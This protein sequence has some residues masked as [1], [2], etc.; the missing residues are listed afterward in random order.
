M[1]TFAL[2]NTCNTLLTALKTAS[3]NKNIIKLSVDI[4]LPDLLKGNATILTNTVKA[5]ALYLSDVLIN[6]VIHIE[7][8]SRGTHGNITT[9][10]VS[11]TGLGNSRS[12][13][14]NTEQEF[15][16]I[17]NNSDFK[18]QFK[19]SED[20]LIFEFAYTL[21][22][23]ESNGVTAAL[24]FERRKILVVEDNEINAMVFSS[25]LEDWGALPA[26]AVNGEEAV[27][28]AHD[29]KYDAILMDIHMP[30]LNGNQATKKIRDFNHDIPIIALTASSNEE[31]FRDAM[32]CGANEYLQKPVSSTNLFQVLSK[33]L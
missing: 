2:R 7:I 31:D 4:Q 19:V 27:T 15:N 32:A 5:I 10:Q 9:A 29:A 26:L 16:S 24:P 6:G 21:T 25:F 20:K 11:I 18:I 3:Q 14:A 22:S 12:K 13:T 1:E 8:T 23:A 33:Y 17:L 30:V 28:M